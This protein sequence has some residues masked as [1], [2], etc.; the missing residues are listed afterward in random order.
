VADELGRT[1]H[2]TVAEGYQRLHRTWPALLATGFVGGID[3]SIG[4]L[5]MLLVKHHTGNDLLAALA[6]SAGFIALT[7]ANS[8]LYTENFLVPIAAVVARKGRLRDV[9][10]LWAGTAVTNLAGGFLMMALILT[11]DPALG[12]TGIELGRTFVDRGIGWL[13]FS[14]AVLAGVVIT[15]M[16]WMQ[17]AT[18]STF[19]QIV[20]AI[21][22][23]FLLAYGHLSHVI[24][25]SLEVFA[26]ILGG[27]DFG[28]AEWFG[29]FLLW[30]AGNTVGGLG[31]V[32]VL[33]LVQVGST[34]LEREQRRPVRQEGT[35]TEPK[36]G[37]GRGRD[38]H[39]PL[40]RQ[41]DGSEDADVKV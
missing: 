8:E 22:A 2:E 9:G 15:L 36:D 10:R 21:I 7:L 11:A 5:G 34:R 33:R 32:T 30:A 35:P 27:A 23:A 14:S 26:G 17:L 25:A 6:F 4:L 31:F 19:G 1:F 16:T 12:E 18:D 28:Y 37:P 13:G 41:P 39:G 24:V 29:M 40:R 20:A 38:G 3:V